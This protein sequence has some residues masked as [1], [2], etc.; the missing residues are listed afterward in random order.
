[1][2][3]IPLIIGGRHNGDVRET[4]ARYQVLTAPSSGCKVL[5]T[6]KYPG[7]RQEFST[8]LMIRRIYLSNQPRNLYTRFKMH[9]KTGSG[10]EYRI[11]GWAG[12]YREVCL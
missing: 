10:L 2:L 6:K 4:K 7:D 8:S 12:S 11:H 5:C 9:E 3:R 1:M